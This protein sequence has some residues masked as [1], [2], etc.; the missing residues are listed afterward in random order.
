[1]MMDN[2]ILGS[3]LDTSVLKI[4]IRPINQNRIEV[5]FCRTTKTN[6]SGYGEVGALN[7]VIIDNVSG[8]RALSE[9]LDFTVEGIMGITYNEDSVPLNGTTSS[10]VV[11]EK[12]TAIHSL[13]LNNSIQLFP[14][15]AENVLYI[16]IEGYNGAKQISML[17]ILGVEVKRIENLNSNQMKIDLQD[18][19]NGIYFVNFETEFEQVTK[20][21]TISK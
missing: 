2:S 20:R 3:E 17:N 12:V 7:F 14:I 13:S 19:K 6:I 1:M 11:N 8:K 9:Q 10:L 5:G 16:N 4:V 21:I 15:P 18:L